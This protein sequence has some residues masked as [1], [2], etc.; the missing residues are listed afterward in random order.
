MVGI[1]V[2]GHPVG[3]LGS[4]VPEQEIR[5]RPVDSW[6]I[7]GE[8]STSDGGRASAGKRSKAQ[9]LQVQNLGSFPEC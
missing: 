5:H 2:D 1:G 8:K 9:Q 7:K 4:Y 3:F 6:F